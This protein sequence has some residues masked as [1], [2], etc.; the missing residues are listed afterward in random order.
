MRYK[1]FDLRNFRGIISAHLPLSEKPNSRVHT[2]VGLNES[3]K[4]TVLEAIN[5][6]SYKSE[7]LD[8][9]DLEGYRIS[10]QHSLIPISKRANFNDSAQISAILELNED[11]EDAIAKVLRKEHHIKLTKPIGEF[12]VTRKV[13][14]ANSRYDAKNSTNLW[15]I[16]A[17]GTANKQRKPRDLSQD[18]ESWPL[19]T[20]TIIPFIPTILFFPNFLFDFPERIYLNPAIE[21]ETSKFYRLLLQD[22]LDSLGN[23]TDV[24]THI[25]ERAQAGSD[26]DKRNLDGLLLD[27]SRHVSR[28]IF[29]AW[30]QMFH[31]KMSQKRV[32]VSCEQD[33]KNEYYVNIRLEDNDGFYQIRERSLGFRWFF[34]FL[35]LTHYRA[36]GRRGPSGVLFLFDEP[37]SNLHPSAQTQLLRSF[38]ALS[39]DC[40]IIYTTHSHHM[41]NPKWLESTFVVKN[42]G[43]DYATDAI[44]YSSKKT[45]ITVT[46]Y[47]EFASKH[48]DQTNYFRPILDVLKYSPSSLENI[49]RVVMVEGKTDYYLLSLLAHTV[50]CD[51]KLYLLPG[52]GSGSLDTL[53]QLYSAWARSF[54]VLLDADTEGESQRKRYKEAFGPIVH[55]RLFLLSELL[56]DTSLRA[57]ETL[58]SSEEKFSLQ[59]LAYPSDTQYNKKHFHRAVQELLI[60]GDTIKLSKEATRRA[61]RLFLELQ[62]KLSA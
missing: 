36:N 3:G 18:T 28:A 8:A 15:S 23:N 27:M 1:C 61:E 6:F 46:K 39:T 58:L 16:S 22:I 42:E 59:Q 53:I 4:T 57:C 33:E 29:S 30:D 14:F 25:L 9:L 2:L 20:K 17:I 21:D 11:D 48:P 5:H 54:V 40:H 19:L 52:T 55:E 56:D 38:E 49:P 60:S 47:R 50:G 35:L 51:E 24:N 44:E 45:D 62:N 31:Q 26:N 43:L 34:V 13:A 7:T 12:T 32:V 41:I 37:A 10:E